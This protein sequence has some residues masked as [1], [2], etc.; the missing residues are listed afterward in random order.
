ML[1]FIAGQTTTLSLPWH[2]FRQP[3][4][5]AHSPATALARLAALRLLLRAPRPGDAFQLRRI[6]ICDRATNPE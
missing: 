6:E 2:W 5:A 4:A 3:D 1:A